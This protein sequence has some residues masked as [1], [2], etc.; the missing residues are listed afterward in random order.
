MSLLRPILL[1]LF[2]FSTVVG[3]GGPQSTGHVEDK[4][5]AGTA[6]PTGSGEDGVMTDE[7]M[8]KYAEEQ[9]SK[10]AEQ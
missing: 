5:P 1:M 6:T 3:C 7:E 2:A 10:A 4:T 8:N 9:S